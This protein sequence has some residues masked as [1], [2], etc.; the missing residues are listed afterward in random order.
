VTLNGRDVDLYARGA[1]S[2]LKCRYREITGAADPAD[3]A[4]GRLA[5]GEAVELAPRRTAL[6]G[7][8]DDR[9]AVPVFGAWIEHHALV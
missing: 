3:E 5:R 8:S 4:L 9:V 6:T 2:D 7:T 1:W